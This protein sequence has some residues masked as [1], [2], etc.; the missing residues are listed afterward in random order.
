MV[1]NRMNCYSRDIT[2]SYCLSV[3]TQLASVHWQAQRVSV[4]KQTAPLLDRGSGSVLNAHSDPSI[5]PHH[6]T[7]TCPIW[8]LHRC[9]L[10]AADAGVILCW[11]VEHG[12]MPGVMASTAYRRCPGH[13]V[14][15]YSR[16][17][18]SGERYTAGTCRQQM[19][20]TLPAQPYWQTA[21]M[22][23]FFALQNMSKLS[24]FSTSLV[25]SF[26]DTRGSLN[27]FTVHSCSQNLPLIS[28]IFA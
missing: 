14:L 16:I 10:T 22:K 12:C 3:I 15:F 5:T 23:N 24:P 7:P 11:F 6:V 19:S 21:V 9:Q 1:D 2:C 13:G 4:P 20:R 17:G 27:F 18:L 25:S 8:P 28:C 26:S